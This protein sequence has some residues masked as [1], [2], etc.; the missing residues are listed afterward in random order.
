MFSDHS[1]EGKLV[2]EILFPLLSNQAT[3]FLDI[4]ELQ[5]HSI[6]FMLVYSHKL[7]IELGNKEELE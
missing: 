7:W 6:N 5:L 1:D 3:N 2:P 4:S